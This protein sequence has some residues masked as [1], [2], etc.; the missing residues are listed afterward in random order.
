MYHC[1]RAVVSVACL[2]T[3]FAA[4]SELWLLYSKHKTLMLIS[5]SIRLLCSL[6][7][8]AFEDIRIHEDV[9]AVLIQTENKCRRFLIESS[10]FPKSLCE[11]IFKFEPY[12]LFPKVAND[13]KLLISELSD[14]K[15]RMNNHTRRIQQAERNYDNVF[16]ALKEILLN[17]GKLLAVFLIELILLGF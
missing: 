12:F 11:E 6:E 9:K 14:S 5:E 10:S 7:T 2:L 17:L 15:E 4:I 8:M 13:A 3:I 16:E 1:F